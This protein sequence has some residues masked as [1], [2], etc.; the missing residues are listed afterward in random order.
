MDSIF[1]KKTLSNLLEKLAE[2]IDLTDS[3]YEKAEERYNRVGEFLCEKGTLLAPYDP[4]TLVQGSIRIGTATRPITEDEGFDVDL[5]CILKSY[6]NPSCQK[7]VKELFETRLRQN[8]NYNRMLDE[9]KRRCWRLLYADEPKFHLDIVPAIPDTYDWL[10]AQGIEKRYAEQAITITDNKNWGYEKYLYQRDLPKSNTEGYALWFLD[11]MK[12]DA[13]SIRKML[14]D[15]YDK[16]GKVGGVPEYKVRTPLQR[17]V[18]L[19]KRHRD[20][21]FSGKNASEYKPVSIVITTLAAKAYEKVIK[22]PHSTMFYDIIMQIVDEMPKF[23]E[24]DDNGKYYIL[25]PVDNGENFAD[26]WNE[27]NTRYYATT[28]YDW[29]SK[30]KQDLQDSY[31]NRKDIYDSIDNFKFQFGEKS[32]VDA[33]KIIVKTEK[34]NP[35]LSVTQPQIKAL[36]AKQKPLWEMV[37]SF[38][39]LRIL[40]SYKTLSGKAH[41]NLQNESLP[42]NTSIR[43]AVTPNILPPYDVYWQITNSGNEAEI[44]KCLRGEIKHSKTLGSGG[45]EHNESTLYEGEHFVECYIVKDGKC[46]A[47]SGDFPVRIGSY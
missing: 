11:V 37:Y 4:H 2:T 38:P 44:A 17:C 30:F 16:I 5:T 31:R 7:T 43:F 28:F 29:H 24:K 41:V 27:P 6:T 20:V 3:Q 10:V 22:Y 40:A 1:D 8:A 32:V 33:F 15:Q 34:P 18:Q 25:N 9:E 21:R 47:R 46:V 36:S 26:K 23:I 19:M 12:V 45:T 42:K 13:D 14:K 35:L 39:T